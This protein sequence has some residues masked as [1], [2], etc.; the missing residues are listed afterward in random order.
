[1]DDYE[2]LDSERL[3]VA[4]KGLLSKDGIETKGRLHSQHPIL[5]SSFESFVK[6]YISQFPE[7]DIEWV[8]DWVHQYE[9]RLVSVD[10]E[11]R[12]ELVSVLGGGE[13]GDSKQKKS[14]NLVEEIT[15]IRN[16]D[17]DES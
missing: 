6:F 9:S 12:K 14:I 3:E 13:M 15:K 4:V 7:L 10:G 11:S 8:L 2:Y 5:L 17:S 1:M 16:E